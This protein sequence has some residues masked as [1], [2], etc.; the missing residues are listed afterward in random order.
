MF[1]GMDNTTYHVSFVSNS[2]LFDTIAPAINKIMNSLKII[3]PKDNLK[4]KGDIPNE[5]SENTIDKTSQITI[6]ENNTVDKA[7][8]V[9]DLEPVLSILDGAATQGN[10]AYY[11]DPIYI[12]KGKTVTVTNDDAVPHTVTSGSNPEDSDSRKLFDT[13][14]MMPG[15]SAKLDTSDLDTGYYPYHCTVHPFMKGLLIIEV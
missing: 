10:P 4:L 6:L 5:T 11:P 9:K 12:S 3:E 15:T 8:N 13:S 14:I 7:E 2:N 1:N